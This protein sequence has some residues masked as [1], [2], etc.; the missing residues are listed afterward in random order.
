MPDPIGDAN[1]DERNAD[2][3]DDEEDAAD[4]SKRHFERSKQV[5][6]GK[7]EAHEGSEHDDGVDAIEHGF[8]LYD[9]RKIEHD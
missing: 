7:L 6:F 1:V 3:E 9:D 5:G 4:F 8:D 2:R